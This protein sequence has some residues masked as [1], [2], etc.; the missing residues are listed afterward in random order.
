MAAYTAVAE[1]DA[2][3]ANR[4]AAASV[5]SPDLEDIPF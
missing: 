1:L 3:E 2:L 5:D 4:V